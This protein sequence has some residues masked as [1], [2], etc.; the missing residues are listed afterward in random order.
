MMKFPRSTFRTWHDQLLLEARIAPTGNG[1][2]ERETQQVTRPKS[3]AKSVRDADRPIRGN[4][5]LR[6]L[7][8]LYKKRERER[9]KQR[10]NKSR[11]CGDD[12]CKRKGRNVL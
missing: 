5:L 1:T 2:L 12:L 11:L 7:L 3:N 6:A 10:K 8:D 4:S 9:E